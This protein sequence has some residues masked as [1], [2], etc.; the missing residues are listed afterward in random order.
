M[1]RVTVRGVVLDGSKIFAVRHFSPNSKVANEYWSTPGGGLEEGENLTDCLTR[2]IK[3]ELGITPDIGNFLFIHQF[4]NDRG[5]ERFDL[6][7]HIKN[8]ADF[9]EANHLDTTHGHEIAEIKFIEYN[10]INLLPNLLSLGE[11]KAI[12]DG[13][14]PAR[15][16]DYLGS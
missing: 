10:N 2:E 11:L 16:F 13:S 14:K 4:I 7:F 5:I 8:S 15:V 3:E 1:R 12:I 6:F 9:T